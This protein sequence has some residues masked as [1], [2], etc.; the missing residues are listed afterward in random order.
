MPENIEAII[1]VC[2]AFD[3]DMY[4]YTKLKHAALVLKKAGFKHTE[5]D[6]YVRYKNGKIK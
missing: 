4:A 2:N 5:K 3:E 1:T 6:E